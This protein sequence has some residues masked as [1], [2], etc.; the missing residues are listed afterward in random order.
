MKTSLVL[1]LAV[2]ITANSAQAQF[3]ALDENELRATTGQAGITIEVQADLS[4][5]E[6]EWHDTG[7]LLLTGSSV[8]AN[9]P[10]IQSSLNQSFSN[11]QSSF[12]EQFSQ[13]YQNAQGG[14]SN[15]FNESTQMLYGGNAWSGEQSMTT[16]PTLNTGSQVGT[17]NLSPNQSHLDNDNF[18]L[19]A[20]SGAAIFMSDFNMDVLG[21]GD[22]LVN[23]G[24]QSLEL[25]AFLP[26]E[27][28]H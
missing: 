23:E 10:D 24:T 27:T 11:S 28:K 1:C 19:Y 13:S 25:N 9:S 12:F 26:L 7:A 5:E 16:S 14:L 2:V 4:K 15:Q 18:G 21:I 6:V 17:M 3:T 22:L 20:A 8:E